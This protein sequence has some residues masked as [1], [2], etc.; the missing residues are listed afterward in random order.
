MWLSYCK[1]FKIYHFKSQVN[2]HP[3]FYGQFCEHSKI[4]NS[5]DVLKTS[6]HLYKT[7]D[8]GHTFTSKYL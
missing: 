8:Y 2:R 5:K 1:E 3:T 7:S 6:L 4:T